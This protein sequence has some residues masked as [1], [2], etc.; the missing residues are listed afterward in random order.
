MNHVASGQGRFLEL[1]DFFHAGGVGLRVPAFVQ[2]KLLHQLFGARSTSAFA[3]DRVFGDEVRASF[4]NT[5][6]R[7]VGVYA[8]VTKLHADDLVA[9]V[10][11]FL[12]GKRR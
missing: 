3:E 11:H 1:P 12:R 7:T 4:E 2:A 6:G 9:V 8:F 10:D 5:F